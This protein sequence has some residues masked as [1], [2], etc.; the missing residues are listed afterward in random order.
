MGTGRGTG[1]AFELCP[2]K[3]A[4]PA[5]RRGTLR[6]SS[7]ISQFRSGRD[8]RFV[9]VVAPAGYGKTTL[10]VQWAAR[11]R[12]RFAWVSL[13]ASDNDP[14]VI[15]SYIASALNAVEPIDQDVFRAVA[16]GSD[17]LWSAAIPRLGSALASV[18]SPIVLVL[19]DVHEVTDSR[20]IDAIDALALNVPAG[21]QLVLAGRDEATLPFARFR[22]NGELLEVGPAELA[23]SD[24][25]A[26]LLLSAAGAQ[27]SDDEARTLNARAEGWPAGLYLAALSLQ[28]SPELQ[29]VAGF[30]GDDRFV[31]DYLRSEHLSQLRPEAVEFLTRTSVLDRMTAPLCDAVLERTG[32]AETL[33]E[34]EHANLFV[35]ALDH[36]SGWYRYHHLFR[37]LLQAELARREPDLVPE[38]NARAA[39]WCAANGMQDWA[40]QHSLAAGDLESASA[41]V[42]TNAIPFIRTG[43]VATVERWLRA[44]D[45][46]DLL[47]RF[48]AV[49]VF[50]TF[51]HAQRGRP[52]TAERWATAVENS[53]YDGVMPDG[54]RSLRPWAALVRA[55]LCKHGMGQ[56]RADAELAIA[57]L[58]P[59]SPLLPLALMFRGVACL[60][61][62]DVAEAEGALEV[63]ADAAALEDS[64]Y[65]GVIAN[66]ELALVALDRGDV[67][68]AELRLVAARRLVGDDARG[69]YVVV[70]LLHAVSARIALERG[71][72]AAARQDL[73]GAQRVRP[74]LTRSLSWLAVQASIE[75]AQAHLALEDGD[76]ARTLCLEAEDV[77]QRTPDVGT[78]G[79]RV[80]ELR[81]ELA[82]FNAP[83]SGWASTLTSAELRLLPLLTTHLSFREIAER[84]LVSRNTVKTQA[85]SVY[86]KLDATS[87]SEAI[88]RAIELG[89]VDEAVAAR[90]LDFTRTA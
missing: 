33:A 56:M 47:D 75:L 58:D 37:D 5:L 20:S 23:L 40:V 32:S 80:A 87:R 54:S 30:G 43:R 42:G 3:L 22:A 90:P 26:I 74:M 70:A 48:P 44:F 35:V 89:L 81:T 13:D 64:T 67:D 24:S 55:L 61:G 14:V 59:R 77:L 4:V 63:A 29:T 16:A 28:A 31:A 79:G 85:I 52:D 21:S 82:A 86:R 2:S 72:G 49:G 10:I 71:R 84:L 39:T 50:G 17:S 62:G 6:R 19:D 53:R 68:G 11:D 15:L 1:A 73:V 38:L 78:L 65:A 69:E 36:R 45:D 83:P 18:S 7:L 9:S 57:E 88:E 8:A 51:I 60:F 66:C 27:V 34:L 46:T 12:R 41:L 76:G 25:E